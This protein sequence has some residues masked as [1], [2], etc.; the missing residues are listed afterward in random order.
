MSSQAATPDSPSAA[1][2]F[3]LPT[4]LITGIGALGSLSA[5]VAELGTSKALIVTDPGVAGTES[6]AALTASFDKENLAY[7]ATTEVEPQPTVDNVLNAAGTYRDEQCDGVVAF[8]GGSAIDT[9]KGVAILATNGG[10]PRDYHGFDLYHVPPAPLIA[11]PTTA[12]T[13]SEVSYAASIRDAERDTKL[14]IRNIR[15]NQARVAILDP[16]VLRSLPARPAAMAGLDA[17]THAIESYTSREATLLTEALSLRAIELIGANLRRFVADRGDLEAGER[18]LVGSTLAGIGFSYAGTGNAHCLARTLA[19]TFHMEHGM[20]CAVTLPHV[21]AYNVPVNPGR[22]ARVAAA[23]GQ[24][25]AGLSEQEASAQA[26][27][28]LF[29]LTS[30]LDTPHS[31]RPFGVEPR[32][33][34]YIAEES[35]AAGYNRWNPRHMTE[36]DFETLVKEM[37]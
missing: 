19:G 2:T 30:N 23:L 1:R 15:Y 12:G 21:V 4:K 35:I 17:L 31:L 26:V 16:E 33:L 5:A 25:T 27:S 24:N 13:G 28:A 20:S 14:T 11:I 32:H 37:L 29:E 36:Q 9:A 3:S 8:G 22:F 18:M 7:A 10:D 6:F 34:K